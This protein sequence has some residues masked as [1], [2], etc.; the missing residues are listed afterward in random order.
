MTA[1]KSPTPKIEKTAP[2]PAVPVETFTYGV[3][4]EPAPT[5]VTMTTSSG[6][7]II[8]AKPR[9]TPVAGLTFWSEAQVGAKYDY[10]FLPAE[11][12]AVGTQVK[13]RAFYC[14]K[15]PWAAYR[16]ACGADV[17]FTTRLTLGVQTVTPQDYAN[18][19][20]VGK[21]TTTWLSTSMGASLSSQQPQI[22][23]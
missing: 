5:V 16:Q 20:A 4:D 1:K 12:Y 8:T 13:D 2:V 18:A 3:Y 11:D 9:G 21:W 10:N 23:A 17:P 14:A 22:R 19:V 15:L 7:G 6:K